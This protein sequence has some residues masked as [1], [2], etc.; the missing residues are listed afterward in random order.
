[1]PKIR[2][3]LPQEVMDDVHALDVYRQALLVSGFYPLTGFERRDVTFVHFTTWESWS[4]VRDGMISSYNKR[5]SEAVAMIGE[6]FFFHRLYR[7]ADP[8]P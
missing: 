7:T 6:Q 5:L 8:G 2:E 4:E 1:M 3:Q